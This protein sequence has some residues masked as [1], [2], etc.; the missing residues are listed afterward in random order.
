MVPSQRTGTHLVEKIKFALL[1]LKLPSSN[2]HKMWNTR[3]ISLHLFSYLEAWWACLVY[4]QNLPHKIY[5]VG[6]KFFAK[7]LVSQIS[8]VGKFLKPNFAC[9]DFG[10]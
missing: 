1:G 2:K 9:L 4:Y 6:Q 8:V 10:N 5:Q 3:E 7:R